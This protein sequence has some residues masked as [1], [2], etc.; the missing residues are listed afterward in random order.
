MLAN[1][2]VVQGVLSTEEHGNV[3]AS[4]PCEPSA[5]DLQVT[6]YSGVCVCAEGGDWRSVLL[7]IFHDWSSHLVV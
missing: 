7:L 1:G 3:T 2:G 6:W 4:V 5:C